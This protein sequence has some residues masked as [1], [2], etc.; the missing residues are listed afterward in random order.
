MLCQTTSRGFTQNGQRP[1]HSW[2]HSGHTLKIN[3]ARRMSLLSSRSEARNRHSGFLQI[4]N[5]SKRKT[6]LRADNLRTARVAGSGLNFV[7]RPRTLVFLPDI[8]CNP[9]KNPFSRASGGINSA[10]SCPDPPHG[11]P[12][13]RDHFMEHGRLSAIPRTTY[14]QLR[15]DPPI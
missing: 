8:E 3:S 7:G 11:K 13:N 5:S 12:R 14:Q 2:W 1:D 6:P 10:G 4:K 15:N 9:F